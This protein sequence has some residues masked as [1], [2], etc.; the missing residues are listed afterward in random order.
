MHLYKHFRD[1]LIAALVHGKT[2]PVPVT[3]G[4]QLLQLFHN[5]PAIFSSPV[6][7]PL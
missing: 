6:P 3:G 4:T 1:R 7:G 5:A 2:L